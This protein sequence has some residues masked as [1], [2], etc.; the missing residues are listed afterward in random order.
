MEFPQR[1]LFRKK[2]S[3]E[4]ILNEIEKEY[5]LKRSIKGPKSPSPNIFMSKLRTRMAAYYNNLCSSKNSFT[6]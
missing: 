1:R 6:K 5:S 3:R 4:K 2:M